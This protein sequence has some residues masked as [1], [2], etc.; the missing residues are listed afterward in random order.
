VA[1]IKNFRPLPIDGC[2]RL[3]LFTIYLFPTLA[4]PFLVKA[5][6]EIKNWYC[7]CKKGGKTIDHLLLHCEVARDLR[8]SIF[9]LFG[10]ERV[11]P[12]RVAELLTC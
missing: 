7:M 9:R 2:L 6:G 12:Q 11:M 5:F 8:E 1:G 10:I 3:D 4:H